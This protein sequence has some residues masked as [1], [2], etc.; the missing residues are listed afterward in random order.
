MVESLTIALNSNVGISMASTYAPTWQ[1]PSHNIVGI[2][3][4]NAL[5]LLSISTNLG[6]YQPTS[7][8]GNLI[9]M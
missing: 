5:Y 3:A 6:T 4:D 7:Y 1:W 8:L 9:P 2:S